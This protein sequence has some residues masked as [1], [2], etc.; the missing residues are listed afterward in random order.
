MRL[1]DEQFGAELRALRET[2]SDSF[3][4]ELD[5]WAAEGFPPRTKHSAKAG[6]A[7]RR[8]SRDGWRLRRRALV[9][10][11]ALVAVSAVV[12]AVVVSSTGENGGRSSLT[13]P[14]A[15][16]LS[17]AAGSA[18][19]GA[20][21]E[22]VAPGTAAPLA[23]P[24]D[25]ALPPTTPPVPGGRPRNGQPQVMERSAQLGLSTDSDKL[26]GA[27]DGVI[28]VTDRYDGYVDSSAV[29]T[30][31]SRAHASFALRI[32]TAR[33]QDALADLSDLGHVSFRNE[34]S[35]NVTDAYVSAGKT[36]ADARA[37]VDALEAQLHSASSASETASIRRQLDVARQ[38]LAAARVGLR[39]LKQ[40]VALTPVSVEITAQGD[41]SWSIGDAADDAGKV[42]EAIGGGLL[43]GL[44]VLVP[45]GLLCGLAWVAT[46]DLRRR[47]REA[48]L[49]R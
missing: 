4:A 14:Q 12:V 11:F 40:R 43:V 34:G 33:L 9:P 25:Q 42:L 3:A 10:A 36:Y 26:Q 20:P 24:N 1:T 47:R 35:V 16:P 6:P 5:A 39:S 48:P 45:L 27:A 18:S 7:Q 46:H 32:P 17:G 15:V 2:P 28:D 21:R 38:E 49:D 23:Q 29:Q 8:L 41:G 37:R 13:A 22:S 30:S 19:A 44:A 31:G